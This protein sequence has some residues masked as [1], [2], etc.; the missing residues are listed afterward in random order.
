MTVFVVSIFV[1]SRRRSVHT[2]GSVSH[3]KNY[4]KTQVCAGKSQR[5]AENYS[6][7]PFHAKSLLFFW[8]KSPRTKE[9]GEHFCLVRW[10]FN[11]IP[12]QKETNDLIVCDFIWGF[13]SDFIG[14]NLR[15]EWFHAEA[16]TK[17]LEMFS[18]FMQ[19]YIMWI[20]QNV[21]TFDSNESFSHC[22]H[23]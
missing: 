18:N 1:L 4:N 7:H 12:M 8:N 22:K 20:M 5:I 16:M 9:N 14:D 13:V 3:Q 11:E 15:G 2:T 21:L 17:L 10:I 19:N 6:P 23:H